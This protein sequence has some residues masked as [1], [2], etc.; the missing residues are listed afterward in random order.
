MS[1]LQ[2]QGTDWI[3]YRGQEAVATK[4]H[5]QQR[6]KDCGGKGLDHFTPT[7]ESDQRVA[8]SVLLPEA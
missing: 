7:V 2:H 4:F 5:Q 8:S 3:S 6:K 1:D